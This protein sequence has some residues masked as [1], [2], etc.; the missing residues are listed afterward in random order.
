MNMDPIYDECQKSGHYT[1]EDKNE[2]D[3]DQASDSEHQN[4]QENCKMSALVTKDT[5]D[6]EEDPSD[7]EWSNSSKYLDDEYNWP[8]GPPYEW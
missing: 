8:S 2:R 3:S 6:E 7:G 1:K 5:N 4:D